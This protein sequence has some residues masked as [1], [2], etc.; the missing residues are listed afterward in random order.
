MIVAV[1]CGE[2]TTCH[3][4]TAAQTKSQTHRSRLVKNVA[5]SCWEVCEHTQEAN[6]SAPTDNEQFDVFLPG[7][8]E[9]IPLGQLLIGDLQFRRKFPVVK[10]TNSVE[11]FRS[12]VPRQTTIRGSEKNHE[13]RQ[14]RA[15]NVSWKHGKLKFPGGHWN[16]Q[17][18][19]QNWSGKVE[20]DWRVSVR[21]HCS[22]SQNSQTCLSMESSWMSQRTN[23]WCTGLQ[24]LRNGLWLRPKW[25]RSCSQSTTGRCLWAMRSICRRRLR[26]QMSQKRRKVTRRRTS[27]TNWPKRGTSFVSKFSE[28]WQFHPV[29]DILVYE[30][31]A[32]GGY[33]AAVLVQPVFPKFDFWPFG[34]SRVIC[35]RQ[36]FVQAALLSGRSEVPTT[37]ASFVHQK[38]DFVAKRSKVCLFRHLTSKVRSLQHSFNWACWQQDFQ[39]ECSQK[40]CVDDFRTHSAPALRTREGKDVSV[41]EDYTAALEE[42]DPSFCHNKSPKLYVKFVANTAYVKSTKGFALCREGEEAAAAAPW[43]QSRQTVGP[44]TNVGWGWTRNCEFWRRTVWPERFSCGS[45]AKEACFLSWWRWYSLVEWVCTSPADCLPTKPRGI[46]FL[47]RPRAHSCRDC[48]RCGKDVRHSSSQKV[49]ATTRSNQ[50][51]AQ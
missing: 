44:W 11:L 17:K 4:D 32:V 26:R 14:Q 22:S 49:S 34:E 29:T 45:D 24:L 1:V 3:R 8:N 2:N 18:T 38:V 42:V 48:H 16:W 46:K 10:C 20:R 12:E 39:Y 51:S 6:K 5:I 41:A 19:R 47:S 27:Q 37:E 21:S 25:R 33:S 9:R 31:P 15:T 35:F 23:Q 40:H 50:K 30:P 28:G 43:H 36:S 13:R 7:S